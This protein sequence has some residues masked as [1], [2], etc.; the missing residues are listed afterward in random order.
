M[1]IKNV[2]EM[3]L[4][5]NIPKAQVNRLH[6][7]TETSESSIVVDDFLDSGW[8]RSERQGNIVQL[9]PMEIKTFLVNLQHA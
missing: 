2:T 8:K 3:N 4:T 6:W 1:Q 9:N 5:G 7:N